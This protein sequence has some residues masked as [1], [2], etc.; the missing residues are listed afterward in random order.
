MSGK[1]KRKYTDVMLMIIK[2]PIF[3]GNHDGNWYCLGYCLNL[4][5]LAC[6]NKK[7]RR[8]RKL[9]K[10]K[11]KTKRNVKKRIEKQRKEEKN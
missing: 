3:A 1:K 9:K 7:K 8:L 6:H 4:A 2:R 10:K 5:L 11:K